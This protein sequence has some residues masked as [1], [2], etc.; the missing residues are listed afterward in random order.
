LNGHPPVYSNSVSIAKI[1]QLSI[2]IQG[3][4]LSV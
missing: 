3:S 2:R 4:V 1:V